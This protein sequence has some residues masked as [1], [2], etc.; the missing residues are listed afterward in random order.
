MQDKA[1]R[2]LAMGASA[3]AATLPAGA[4]DHIAGS[5]KNG[6]ARPEA[7]VWVIAET[8]DLPTPFR[9]IVVTDGAGRFVLPELPAANYRVWV[10]GYGLADSAP[11]EARPGAEL[12]LGATVAADP[13]EAALVY[14]A[15]AWLS[16]FEPP[17]HEAFGGTGGTGAGGLFTG[18]GE[19]QQRDPF[20]SGAEWFAQFK[21]NCVLC[22]QVGAAATRLPDAAAFD[23][24]FPKAAGMNYFADTLGRPRLLAA[25]GAWGARLAEGAT[26]GAPSRPQGLER[27][28]VITQ[29]AWAT[30]TP[31]RTTRWPRTSAIRR[32]TPV[33]R[34]TAWTSRT[35][36]C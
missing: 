28:V 25:M 23:H 34:C 18:E 19:A 30:S 7:G 20:P 10:R 26:P 24:G 29:W 9:K 6:D 22:H 13:A 17:P 15:S 16:L 1:V 33:A 5:V 35:I 2:A 14:P 27:N 32:S 4:A 11:V 36:A 3:L 12:A 21:L 31:T 8:E